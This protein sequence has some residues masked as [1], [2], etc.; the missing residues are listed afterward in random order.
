MISEFGTASPLQGMQGRKQ[1]M[2]MQG[3]HL[4]TRNFDVLAYLA[5]QCFHVDI[6]L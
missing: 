5:P 2:R 6:S 4:K 3:E 1:S